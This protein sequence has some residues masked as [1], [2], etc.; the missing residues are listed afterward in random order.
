MVTCG[1]IHN[2]TSFVVVFNG[3]IYFYF[4]RAMNYLTR[5]CLEAT[6]SSGKQALPYH[7]GAYPNHACR[8]KSSPPP[9]AGIRGLHTQGL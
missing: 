1:N 3:H 6:D 7:F 2:P 9:L 5:K 4:E 8:G